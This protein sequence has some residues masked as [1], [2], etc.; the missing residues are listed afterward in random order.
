MYI[1][2]FFI[3]LF[4]CLTNSILLNDNNMNFIINV[5]AWKRYISTKRL[6]ESLKNANY[7][8]KSI[9][10]VI[11][12]EYNS[13]LELENYLKEFN[14]T[15]GKKHII[16]YNFS[17]G[18]ER[19]IINSWNPK[20]NNEFAFF[21]EDDIEVHKNYFQFSLKIL[22]ELNSFEGIVGISLNT[23]KFDQINLLT[24]IWDPSKIMEEGEKLFLFQLPNSWGALYFPSAW[25]RFQNFYKNRIKS[26]KNI[27]LPKSNSNYWTKSWKKY[28]IE[29][30]VLESLLMVYPSFKDQVGYSIHHRE[31]GE[32]IKSF[33]KRDYYENKFINSTMDDS[34]L[35]NFNIK[36]YSFP[37]VSLYHFKTTLENLK[38]FAN[39]LNQN[40]KQ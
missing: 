36:N 40:F 31:I 19:L 3:C 9:D 37:I 16:K 33:K 34:F 18:L 28:F 32:H 24:G 27:F 35:L 15:H 11:H 30:M 12:L 4:S 2:I 38:A 21:F 25:S 1:I 20:S 7:A 13:S 29:F 23:P 26:S 39:L 22:K 10:L 17:Q 5:F 14:W 8:G 6:I